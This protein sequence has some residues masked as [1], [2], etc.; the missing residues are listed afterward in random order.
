VEN[1]YDKFT[2]EQL[3]ELL[4]IDDKGALN[5]RNAYDAKVLE[6]IRLKKVLLDTNK[7]IDKA[8]ELLEKENYHCPMSLT[9]EK[10]YIIEV[11]KINNVISI[12]RG[13][14]NE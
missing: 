5:L 3:I 2:K 7:R 6:N 10:A 8:I 14:D 4:E 11:E 13:E 12:L 9:V 1:K